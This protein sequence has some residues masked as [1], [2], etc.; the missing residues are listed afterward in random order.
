MHRQRKA[1]SKPINS[2][3]GEH[4]K[5]GT[6]AAQL[7]AGALKKFLTFPSGKR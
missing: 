1:D 4:R 5:P 7:R 6:P 2:K 3:Q